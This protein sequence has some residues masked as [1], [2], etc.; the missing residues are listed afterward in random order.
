MK[1]IV[2]IS[3]A[4]HVL[5]AI[6]GLDFGQQYTKAVL[7]APGVQFEMVLTV[8]GKRKDLS[9]ISIRSIGADGLERVYGSQTGSLCSR[10]PHSCILDLKPL[11]GSSIDDVSSAEYLETHL[12]VKLIG[13]DS[14]SGAVKFDLG[15]KNESYQFT[16][17]EILAMQ[18]TEIKLRAIHD[19]ENS[20][21]DAIPLVDDVAVTVPPFATHKTKQAYLDALSLAGFNNVLGLV[22]E[23]TAAALTFLSNKKFE[24][25]DFNDEKQYHVIYDMGAGPVKATLFSFTPF[26]NGSLVLEVE[27]VGYDQSLGGKALTQTIYDKLVAQ[28]SAQFKTIL[29][30]KLQAKLWETAEKAKLILSINTLFLA[31]LESI[32]DEKDFKCTISRDE[33]EAEYD[34]KRLIKPITDALDGVI[35][36]Y[37]LNSVV[38]NGG[39]TRIPFVQRQLTKF[40]GEHRISKSI[41][42][43][44]SC[45]MGTTLRA[46]RLKT[47]LT[48]STDIVLIDKSFNTHSIQFGETNETV[49]DKFSTTGQTKKIDFGSATDAVEVNLFE[50]DDQTK[51][52][53]F[54]DI[55]KKSEKLKCPSKSVKNIV[56]TFKLDHSKMFDL[57]ELNVE[58]T[59]GSG[60]LSK[61]WKKE[62]EGEVEIEEEE[63]AKI[64]SN[65]TNSTYSYVPKSKKQSSVSIPLVKPTYFKVK[66]LL[67]ITKAKLV[68]KLRYLNKQDKERIQVDHQRNVLEATC[69]DLRAYLETN[70]HPLTVELEDLS[71]YST[72][73]SDTIEWLEF[74]SDDASLDQIN[75][76]IEYLSEKKTT[77]TKI[78]DM[79]AIDITKPGLKTVY[80]DGLSVA[81]SIESN[82][83]NYGE[84]VAEVRSRYDEHGIDFDKENRR[85]RKTMQS[86]GGDPVEKISELVTGLKEGLTTLKS[87][88]DLADDEFAAVSKLVLFDHHDTFTK[89]MTEIFQIAAN[90]RAHHTDRLATLNGKLD[91]LLNRKLQKEV[92]QKLKEAEKEAVK[93]GKKKVENEEETEGVEFVEEEDV[94]EEI[95]GVKEEKIQEEIQEGEDPKVET[96]KEE[97]AQESK[98]IEPELEHDEL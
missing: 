14:R 9:G 65:D 30:A 71:E 48:K 61:L 76:K 28:F 19:L 59:K 10:F 44:E 20:P 98:V 32:H 55:L 70:E 15:F 18:L 79:S 56:G 78:V 49:F 58:C 50:N 69:Y 86:K 81:V 62:E 31:T 60:L 73:V 26:K 88:I 80:E 38:L 4:T 75:K 74:E 6:M 24:T 43:D 63:T 96:D 8:E 16:A 29:T 5:G 21:G 25:E 35:S 52:Y 1:L 40:V 83:L 23:G 93:A 72:A 87:V 85:L 84:E 89:V 34:D 51:Q 77:L 11:L 90:L 45:A 13:E 37:Q 82:L 46:L 67:R 94:E 53:A 64:P 2:L 97:V 12:G 22:D 57:V 66:P 41:N 17:E 68:D 47:S 39:S 91:T 42:T 27:N 33:F 3:I 92:R 7:L 95:E 36:L 54:V